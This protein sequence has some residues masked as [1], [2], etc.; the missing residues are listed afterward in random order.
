MANTQNGSTGPL[1]PDVVICQFYTQTRDEQRAAQSLE[2]AAATLVSSKKGARM[3]KLCLLD[4]AEQTYDYYQRMESAELINALKGA[5]SIQK[6][7]EIYIKKNDD[8]E[9]LIKESSKMLGDLKMKLQEANNT[10]C[11]TSNCIESTLKKT[12]AELK[13]PDKSVFKELRAARDKV[14]DTAKS[15]SDSGQV[16]FNSIV[17]IAGIQTFSD[18]DN[19]KPFGQKL[20]DSITALKTTTGDHAKKATDDIKTAQ[21]ELTK[22]TE[23]LTLAH[24]KKHTESVQHAALQAM[25][26]FICK[27]ECNAETVEDI[28]SKMQA[29]P[30]PAPEETQNPD[31]KDYN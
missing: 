9:K 27:H 4:K 19:L 20:L 7:I 1:K 18:I 2:T 26:D 21:T 14:T 8:L 29:I 10:A 16:I 17:S 30:P 6:N 31:D 13:N 24:Y 25:T 22:I 23:E 5:E 11:I 28:C 12:E 3:Y 15:L